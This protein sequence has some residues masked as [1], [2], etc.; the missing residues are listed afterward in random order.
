MYKKDVFMMEGD[1]NDSDGSVRSAFLELVPP[2]SSS[3]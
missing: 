3:I 2:H 1:S